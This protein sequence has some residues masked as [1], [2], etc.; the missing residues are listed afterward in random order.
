LLF[1]TRV[2]LA[3][4]LDFSSTMK[5]DAACSSETSTKFYWTVWRH[6]PLSENCEN[7]NSSRRT[8]VPVPSIIVSCAD[9]PEA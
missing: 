1:S 7:L 6:G 9:G 3:T 5:M 8:C 4:C 2:L